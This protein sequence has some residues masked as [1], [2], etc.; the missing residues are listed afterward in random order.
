MAE[1]YKMDDGG[2]EPAD[3]VRLPNGK[4]APITSVLVSNKNIAS[5]KSVTVSTGS[6]GTVYTLNSLLQPSNIKKRY[7]VLIKN[8]STL[9]D[10]TVQLQNIFGSDNYNLGDAITVPK[11]SNKTILVEGLFMGDGSEIVVSPVTDVATDFDVSV[12][13][14]EI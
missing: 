14:F 7:A 4:V 8:P 9:V 2:F 1:E 10:V 13:I 11:S 12:N 6:K 3:A 5:N